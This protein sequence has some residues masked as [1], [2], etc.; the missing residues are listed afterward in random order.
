MKCLLKKKEGK[1]E[2]KYNYFNRI[3][4]IQRFIQIL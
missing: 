2:E 4:Y 3:F 1:F